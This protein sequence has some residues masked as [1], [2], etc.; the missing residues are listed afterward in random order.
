MVTALEEDIPALVERCCDGDAAAWEEFISRFHARIARHAYKAAYVHGA[1]T[2][3]EV[4]KEYLQELYVRLLANEC[5]ALRSWR[6]ETEGS[7]V[8]YLATVMHTVAVDDLRRRRSRKRSAALVSLDQPADADDLSLLERLSG[9]ESQSPERRLID[10]RTIERFQQVLRSAIT[11]P[12]AARNTL[13][14][15]LHHFEGFSAR[16]IAA[17]PCFGMN[18]A[19]VE[20]TLRRTRERLRERLGGADK[21]S[22]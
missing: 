4:A 6:G 11:G 7:L 16:E 21:L 18:V 14:F 3:A 20:A 19:G 13:I 12:N 15:Q 1:D 5:H 2:R 17:M 10:G 9:P 22:G 8:A